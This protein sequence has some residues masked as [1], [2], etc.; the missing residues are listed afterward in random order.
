MIQPIT[1]GISANTTW[2]DANNNLRAMTRNDTTEYLKRCRRAITVLKRGPAGKKLIEEIDSS[3]HTVMVYPDDPNNFGGSWC[4]VIG[5]PGRYISLRANSVDPED[6]KTKTE[7]EIVLKRAGVFTQRSASPK[8]PGIPPKKT[9]KSLFSRSKPATTVPLPVGW[10]LAT[11][12]KLLQ[13]SESTLLNRMAGLVTWSDDQEAKMK[14]FLER[15][16]TPGPG[17]NTIVCWNFI[18]TSLTRDRELLKLGHEGWWQNR[19]PFISLGHELIH[20]WRQ[21]TGRKLFNTAWEE[22][23]MTVG[24]PPFSQYTPTENLLRSESPMEM[25]I[26]P[27][28]AGLETDNTTFV[29]GVASPDRDLLTVEGQKH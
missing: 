19:P 9:F 15:F 27:D 10:S 25:S 22:E 16:L 23:L 2:V 11:V 7:L 6:G 21:M 3:G 5:A 26:R 24:L 13:I 4:N 12:A 18:R 8:T 28:Y 14:T 29:K 1:N 20:A 17:G